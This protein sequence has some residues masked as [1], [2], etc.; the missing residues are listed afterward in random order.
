[1]IVVAI[2]GILAAIAILQ[3]AQF[4][5]NSFVATLNSDAKNAYTASATLI[6]D[7]AS[8]DTIAKIQGAGYTPS[9]GVTPTIAYVSNAQYDILITG[10]AGWGLTTNVSTI[11]QDGVLTPAAP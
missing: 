8:P 1:M 5:K 6:A 3:F 7:G 9:S 4:R 10:T 2:I 11:G